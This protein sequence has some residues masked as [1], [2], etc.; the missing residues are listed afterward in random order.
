MN[1]PTWVHCFPMNCANIFKQ[2]VSEGCRRAQ[3][4]FEIPGWAPEMRG[5]TAWRESGRFVPRKRVGE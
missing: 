2:E 5:S 4:S 3:L 1:L